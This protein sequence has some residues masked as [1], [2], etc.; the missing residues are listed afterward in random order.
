VG[1][2][3]DLAALH[4]HLDTSL[5]SY[6]RPVFVR[7][8]DELDTTGTFKHQKDELAREGYDPAATDDAIYFHDA[9][10]QTYLRMDIA[11]FRLLRNGQMRL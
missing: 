7:I 3:F 8:R 10:E 11:R 5:P 2:G 6:A 9:Q 1:D 4:R